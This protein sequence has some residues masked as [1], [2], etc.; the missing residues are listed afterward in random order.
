MMPITDGSAVFGLCTICLVKWVKFKLMTVWKTEKRPFMNK[1]QRLPLGS[2]SFQNDTKHISWT[3]LWMG[4]TKSGNLPT[5][6]CFSEGNLFDSILSSNSLLSNKF[7]FYKLMPFI[8]GALAWQD[9]SYCP[10]VEHDDS[11]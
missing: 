5:S 6:Y 2:S 7:I 3:L 10:W 11:L 4:M 8:H 1:E 9:F